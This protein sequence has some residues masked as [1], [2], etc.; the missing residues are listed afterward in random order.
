[1]PSGRPAAEPGGR[2]RRTGGGLSSNFSCAVLR[3]G[4]QAGADHRGGFFL[5][6][7]I[8]FLG[9]QNQALTRAFEIGL[10]LAHLGF[11]ADFHRR[12]GLGHRGIDA[13]RRE[14]GGRSEPEPR[15]G[16]PK[17]SQR[18]APRRGLEDR[19]GNEADPLRN[20]LIPERE[21]SMFRLTQPVQLFAAGRAN[22]DM[23]FHLEPLRVSQLPVKIIFEI[24]WRATRGTHDKPRAFTGA[25][26][27]F[28]SSSA[29]YRRDLTVDTG[30][31]RISAISSNLK[32]W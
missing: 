32:P 16:I 22:S 26:S 25:S 17:R 6:V 14:H 10:N 15:P 11:V 1:M 13:R 5:M 18:A 3:R 28:N 20:L 8:V 27:A 2:G 4:V 24:E 21:E 7:V 31:P 19:I 9:G 12:Y 30:Q 29:V 23:R